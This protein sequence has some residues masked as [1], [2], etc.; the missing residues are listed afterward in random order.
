MLNG[1][2]DGASKAVHEARDGRSLFR[3][4]D[5]KFTRAAIGI[6]SHREVALMSSHVELVRDRGAFFLKF[7]AYGPRRS[8]G[9]LFFARGHR[10]SRRIFLLRE[11]RR[12]S[13]G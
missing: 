10:D 2:R 11:S 4:G 1:D 8:V 7:V 5:E 13:G 6:E 9:I 3:H 12:T